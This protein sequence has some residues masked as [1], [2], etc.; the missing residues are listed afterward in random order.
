MMQVDYNLEKLTNF[1]LVLPLYFREVAKIDCIVLP[2]RK[3]L[4]F[5]SRCCKSDFMSQERFFVRKLSSFDQNTAKS[6][7]QCP[8]KRRYEKRYR[9]ITKLQQTRITIQ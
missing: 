6:P 2:T 4:A 1:F 3:T 5:S 7:L 8:S 9:N